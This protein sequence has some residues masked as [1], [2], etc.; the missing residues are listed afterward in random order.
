MLT[1]LLPFLSAIIDET[2]AIISAIESLVSQKRQQYATVLAS[3]EAADAAN[4]AA[5][6]AS[7]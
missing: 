7:K 3:I 6:E 4:V 5:L 1:A 2:P